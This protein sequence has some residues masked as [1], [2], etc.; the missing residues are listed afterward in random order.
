MPFFYYIFTGELIISAI[1]GSIGS[2][3]STFANYIASKDYIVINADDIS[4]DILSFDEKIKKKIIKEFGSNSYN[5]GK[6]NKKFIAAQVFS[7]PANLNKLNSILHPRVLQ[8]I[9]TLI[10]KKYKDE[11]IVFIEAA[12]IYEADIEK[13]FDYVVLVTADFNIRLKRS[14]ANGKFTEDDFINRDKSQIPQEEKEKRADFIFSNN[15]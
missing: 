7:D 13:K 14:V 5:D 10:E 6:L 15:G 2:G 3:K 1:T 8:K 9:D 4:K 12:L 11:K